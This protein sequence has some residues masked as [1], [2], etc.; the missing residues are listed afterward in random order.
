M[1]PATTT[2]TT[3]TMTMSALDP[4]ELTDPSILRVRD[5]VTQIMSLS[6]RMI[7]MRALEERAHDEEFHLVAKKL[8]N[9]RIMLRGVNR[10][11]YLQNRAV[12]QATADAKAEVDDLYLHLQ[13]LKYEQGHLSSEIQDCTNYSYVA[14]LVC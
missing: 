1:A 4:P 3:T 13:N 8:R 6:E 10:D 12:K 11:M 5:T 2:T 7:E 14:L 9:L